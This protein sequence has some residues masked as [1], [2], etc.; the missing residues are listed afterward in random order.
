MRVLKVALFLCVVTGQQE[1][2]LAVV[3]ECVGP[4]PSYTDSTFDHC[5]PNQPTGGCNCN[6]SAQTCSFGDQLHYTCNHGT[7]LDF[8]I[9]CDYKDG[10]GN[11]GFISLIALRDE[12][13][14]C[15][16]S[17]PPVASTPPPAQTFPPSVCSEFNVATWPPEGCIRLVGSHTMPHE[18]TGILQ[19]Y[20][21]NT[22]GSVCFTGIWT[23][24]TLVDIACRMLGFNRHGSFSALQLAIPGLFN[25]A[26]MVNI[27]HTCPG[28][29]DSLWDCARTEPCWLTYAVGRSGICPTVLNISCEVQTTFPDL[30]SC[31]PP[32]T[33][34]P[35]PTTSGPDVST[36]VQHLDDL[37]QTTAS[38]HES[39]PN[40]GLPTGAIVGIA[41][42]AGIVFLGVVALLVKKNEICKGSAQG[43]QTQ[44]P[45]ERSRNPA[46]A[47]TTPPA[48]PGPV[49]ADNGQAAEPEEPHDP[50]DDAEDV[51]A[52]GYND[53][54]AAAAVDALGSRPRVYPINA[55]T[56][57]HEM[58]ELSI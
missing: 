13:E 44:Q 2:T 15:T 43:S 39:S 20:F 6:A 58:P 3:N 31:P 10:L 25:D 4:P 30:T 9:V 51:P 41:A 37:Q 50:I 28:T 8:I 11:F 32:T 18:T 40:T 17:P 5:V 47:D 21:N 48:E 57:S 7:G 38:G 52:E 49:H 55:P 19:V 45:N 54:R 56:E 27:Q 23:Q 35:N 12:F 14:D 34:T 26:W 29:V 46:K 22:W 53:P 42:V 1:G 16:G 33:T 36:H 24:D